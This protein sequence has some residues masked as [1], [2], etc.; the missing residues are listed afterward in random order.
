MDSALAKIV[1]NNI[2]DSIEFNKR[3]KIQEI[4]IIIKFK[5]KE[6]TRVHFKQV[7]DQMIKNFL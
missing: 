2:R 7:L 1:L 3:K 6:L 4:Q 5:A